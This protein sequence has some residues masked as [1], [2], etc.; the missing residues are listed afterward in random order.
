[1]LVFKNWE[2]GFGSE[3]MRISGLCLVISTFVLS[4]AGF[5]KFGPDEYLSPNAAGMLVLLG[6]AI[7]CLGALALKIHRRARSAQRRTANTLASA[8][9]N[10]ALR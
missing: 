8:L 10:G 4:I 7:A 3:S 6:D 1:M 5:S 9:R 2:R